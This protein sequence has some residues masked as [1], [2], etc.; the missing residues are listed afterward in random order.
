LREQ[1]I[2]S[3]L[4]KLQ[5]EKKVYAKWLESSRVK[6]YSKID[7]ELD[8]LGKINE[9]VLEKIRLI[10]E[11]IVQIKENTKKVK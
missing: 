6:S 4:P 7:Q 11:E 3:S 10:N 2:S 9:I 1:S 8:E 5:N